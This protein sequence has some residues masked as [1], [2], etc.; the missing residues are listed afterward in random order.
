LFKAGLLLLVGFFE[1]LDPTTGF[2][3]ELE[4]FLSSFLGFYFYLIASSFLLL[5]CWFD[6]WEFIEEGLFS[7]FVDFSVMELLFDFGKFLG[8]FFGYTDPLLMLELF[9]FGGS[10]FFIIFAD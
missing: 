4:R 9:C 1:L 7:T 5:N 8:I 6:C 10:Y 3:Y 2:L